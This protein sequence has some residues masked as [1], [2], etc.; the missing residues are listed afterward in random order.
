MPALFFQ[1]TPP[2]GAA[3]TAPRAHAR[4]SVLLRSRRP[5]RARRSWQLTAA[6]PHKAETASRGR[7]PP[8]PPRPLYHPRRICTP[9]GA[10]GP[11][12]PAREGPGPRAAARRRGP[13]PANFQ[14][15]TGPRPLT[16]RRPPAGARPRRTTAG[17][18]RAAPG[19]LPFPHT[20]VIPWRQHCPAARRLPRTRAP[21]RAAP[22]AGAPLFLVFI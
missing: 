11:C 10:A 1:L 17:A 9:R 5:P 22:G 2:A 21:R 14:N 7:R 16:G 8:A 13:P 19:L 6:L 12:P 20:A 15:L 4:G 3:G 18:A